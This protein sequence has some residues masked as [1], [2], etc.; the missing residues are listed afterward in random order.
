MHR[1][2][3]LAMVEKARLEKGCL[4]PIVSA[5]ARQ[6]HIAHAVDAR[7]RALAASY[8]TRVSALEAR[9]RRLVV[10]DVKRVI[11]GATLYVIRSRSYDAVSCLD[12]TDLMFED[13][14]E[15]L[16][17]FEGDADDIDSPVHV[18][19]SGDL[20]YVADL[21]TLAALGGVPPPPP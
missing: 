13:P 8:D 17:Y 3:Y 21:K 1:T 16:G 5:S 18:G 12:N 19:S 15:P 11:H 10:A 4:V 7:L 9:G 2:L 20:W 6:V 14:F